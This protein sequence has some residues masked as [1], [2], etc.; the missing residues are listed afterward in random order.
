[1]TRRRRYLLGALAAL[2]VSAAHAQDWPA[3]PVK[4]VAPFPPGGS[5]DTLARIVAEKLA[6]RLGQ[7]FIVEN[8]A[9]AGGLIGSEFVAK[10]SPD[11]YTLV[12]S[13]VASHV[14]APAM[15][16]AP[17]DPL[18]SFTHVA[19]FGGPPTV[20]VVNPGVPARDLKEFIALSKSRTEG[21][22]FGS[23]GQG[24]H[25]HLIVEML[26]TISGANLSH[27]PYK[28]AALAIAD[29]IG[30]HIPAAST[31][32]TTAATQ[33]KAG[34]ARPLAVS[35]A[36]RLPDFAG[37][38]TYVE[39]G[40]P[41]IVAIT[42]FSLSGPAGLPQPIVSRLNSEV[43]AILHQPDVRERLAPDGFEPNDLDAAAFT[44]FV[45]TEID[46]WGPLAKALK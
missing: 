5:A 33:I 30:G 34:K 29:L 20:L 28:G 46:R 14:I 10:A 32:L 19:L 18:K 6:G 3:R 43:R 22:S 17:F 27:V 26:R 35:S 8:R 31:T 13:G 44:E 37:V 24:T 36:Q 23:P 45:R 42:W 15:T 41:D 25:G 40:F 2:A 12:V 9:G 4:I 38:P 11:G 21:L 1:M 7:N 16:A 39:S